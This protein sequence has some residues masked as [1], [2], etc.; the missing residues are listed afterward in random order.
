MRRPWQTF[1]L[2]W[3]LLPQWIVHIPIARTRE[4]IEQRMRSL[5]DGC[6]ARG[7]PQQRPRLRALLTASE[8]G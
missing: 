8:V 7:G 5:P 6:T 4:C 3:T 2:L 1:A